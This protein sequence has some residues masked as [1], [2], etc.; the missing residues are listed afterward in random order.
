VSAIAV[1][2]ISSVSL[3]FETAA[4][5]PVQVQVV[6]AL[7]EGRSVVRAAAEAGIHRT[8]IHN[9]MRTS[10]EF[11]DAVEQASSHFNAI[12][13]DQLKELSAA[14]LETLRQLLARPDTPPSVRLR[15]ALAVLERPAYP[16]QEWQVPEPVRLP[17]LPAPIPEPVVE[18]STPRNA[19]CPCGS[20]L[21]FKRCCGGPAS[22]PTLASFSDERRATSDERAA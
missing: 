21:K 6:A 7:A 15:A 19:P 2:H 5:T 1:H 20:G 18:A 3:P 8:T 10:Q 13:A 14:A 17:R 12:V 4:L 9:W 11:R 16:A 22:P